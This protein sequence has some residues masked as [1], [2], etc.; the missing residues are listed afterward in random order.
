MKTIVIVLGLKQGAEVVDAV[1]DFSANFSALTRSLTNRY[2]DAQFSK[3]WVL[4][5]MHG[6]VYFQKAK[7]KELETFQEI[8]GPKYCCFD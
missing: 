1:I 3:R 2:P 7:P 8:K 5:Q 4:V 6:I